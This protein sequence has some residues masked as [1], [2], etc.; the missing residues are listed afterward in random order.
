MKFIDKINKLTYKNKKKKMR[1]YLKNALYKIKV[2]AK[3]GNNYTYFYCLDDDSKEIYEFIF[4]ELV[5]KGFK[6]Y[7]AEG[8][9]VDGLTIK[10]D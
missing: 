5:S 3:N 1:I 2:A 4:N 9:K 10:W 6:V 7:E 8:N